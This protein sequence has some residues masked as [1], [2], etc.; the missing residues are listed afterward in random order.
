[1]RA[2]ARILVGFARRSPRRLQHLQPRPRRRAVPLRRR[3]AALPARLH[4]RRATRPT[5]SCASDRRR[6][7]RRRPDGGR[8]R[9]LRL[10]R[11]RRARAERQ[12]EEAVQTRSSRSLQRHLQARSRSSICPE[13]DNDYF[14]FDV[15]VAG[16]E[17]R[18]DLTYQ[19]ATRPAHRR[20]LNAGGDVDPQRRGGRRRCRTC[21]RAE[22]PNLPHG[23]Y[24]VAGARPGAASR[25]TT[26]IEIALSGALSGSRLAIR[27]TRR[28]QQVERAASSART[29]ARELVVVA[30]V[31]VRDLAQ[32]RQDAARSPS[33]AAGHQP[34][35]QSLAGMRASSRRFAVPHGS[36]SFGIVHAAFERGRAGNFSAPSHTVGA[37]VRARPS[38]LTV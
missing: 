17:P 15:D 29:S 21:V 3:R 4:L 14:L 28:L 19:S 9:R 5:R 6:R 11:R 16:Q 23:T 12:L 25:T 34:L 32:P 26:R 27:S 37:H 7:R 35:A 20:V 31:V 1:M 18:A 33:C 24:Y 10:R 38:R 13:T 30:G 22:V 36:A 2:H 8:R